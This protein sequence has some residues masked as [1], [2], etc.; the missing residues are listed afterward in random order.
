MTNLLDGAVGLRT[1]GPAVCSASVITKEHRNREQT[2][3]PMAEFES[4]A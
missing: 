4:A 3:V 1:W 2:S